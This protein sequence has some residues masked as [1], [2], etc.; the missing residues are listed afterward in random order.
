MTTDQDQEKLSSVRKHE[1]P[2]C[3]ICNP[4]NALGLGLDFRTTANGTVV[5][6]FRCSTIFQGYPGLLHG[7]V[8]ALLL[9]GAMTNCLF[10]HNKTAVTGELSIKYVEP[11]TLERFAFVKA[12]ITYSFPPLHVLEAELHQGGKVLARAKGKFMERPPDITSEG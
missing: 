11:V 4:D 3:V 1:H 2:H 7:G 6:K 5:A 12:W 8:T 9:D 10:A